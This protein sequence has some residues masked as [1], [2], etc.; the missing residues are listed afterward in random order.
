MP[1]GGRGVIVRTRWA[2]RPGAVQGRRIVAV[3][4]SVS[5][6]SSQI[7]ALGHLAI[8]AAGVGNWLSGGLT[9]PGGGAGMAPEPGYSGGRRR[10]N[11]CNPKALRRAIRRAKA[12]E[13]LALRSIR[14]VSPHRLH[15]KRFGGFKHTKRKRS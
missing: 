13:K 3:H 14:L 6:A 7:G 9:A 2:G 8:G 1:F 15:G 11:P 10:M 4:P 12:F 5:A